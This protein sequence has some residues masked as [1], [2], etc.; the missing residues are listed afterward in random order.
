MEFRKV[1][2]CRKASEHR[3]GC[4]LAGSRRK[5]QFCEWRGRRE[6][7]LI[8]LRCLLHERTE[9]V[10]LPFSAESITSVV[11]TFIVIFVLIWY[12]Y[13][14]MVSSYSFSDCLVTSENKW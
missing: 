11:N 2:E 7:S 5:L 3:S 4:T 1:D 6:H 8:I 10:S 9:M 13:L 14:R 12:R